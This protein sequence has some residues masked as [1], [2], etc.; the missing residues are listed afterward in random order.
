MSLHIGALQ[1]QIAPLV[2][3]PGDPQRA[4]WIAETWLADAVC[5]NTVRGMLGFTGMW[6]GHRI[7]VQGSGIGMPSMALYA[8]ELFRD[9]GVTHAVRV[10]TCGGLQP[11]LALGDLVLAMS[12]STDS[13]FNRRGLGNL[14]YAPTA[15][16]RMLRVAADV[17]QRTGPHHVG[18]VASMDAFYDTTD[19]TEHLRAHGVLAVEMETSA[20]YTIAARY[21]AR[22]L[23]VLTVSDH[24]LT[25]AAMPAAQRER[26]LAPM[27]EVALHAL[28]EGSKPD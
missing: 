5:H 6:R 23:T 17:A 11:Q 10:G 8:T 19:A 27:V 25:G 21:R 15:D 7:S 14:D 28:L 9:F 20:L 13:N 4:R 24:L 16:W 12:A 1:G 22:A 18:G 2:L 26:D 3:M